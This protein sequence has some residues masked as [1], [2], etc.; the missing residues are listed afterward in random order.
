MNNLGFEK[1]LNPGPWRQDSRVE[2]R[3]RC[4]VM[5]RAAALGGEG[6]YKTVL[7]LKYHNSVGLGALETV[8]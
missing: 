2:L 7:S 6:L 5:F 1:D 8:F 3:Y 4:T